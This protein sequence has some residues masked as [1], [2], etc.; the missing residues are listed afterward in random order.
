MTARRFC[1]T[2]FCLSVV[3]M[4]LMLVA[5]EVEK[6]KPQTVIRPVRYQRVVA[7]SAERVRT[8]AGTARAGHETKL[9]FKVDGTIRRLPVKV[10][11]MLQPGDLVAEIDPKDYALRTREAEA[12]LAR[13]RA[14]VRNAGASYSRTRALYENNN[15]SRQ[16]LDAARATYESAQA[17]VRSYQTQ[18]E[19]ARRQV[20]YTR[21]TTQVGGAVAQV[22]MEVNENV[23]AGQTI[24]L[25]TSDGKLEVLVAIPE[26]FIASIARD[27]PVEVTFDALPGERFAAQVTEV[28]VAATGAATT[29]PVTVELDAADPRIRSGLAANVRFAFGTSEDGQRLIAPVQ[30]VGEDQQGRFVFLVEPQGETGGI[31]RRRPVTVGSLSSEGLEIQDGLAEGDLLVIA[32]V[33]RLKDGQEVKVLASQEAR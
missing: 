22:P 11:D 10:G 14:E 20:S 1:S 5:C 16:E 7:A 15:A 33:K 30:A 3:G 31:V 13:S 21:L 17:S 28:G 4:V 26:V 32:G 9:S 12:A 27:N 6:P 29:F 24:A 19:Q 8:F 25:L 2:L 18:V 23:S